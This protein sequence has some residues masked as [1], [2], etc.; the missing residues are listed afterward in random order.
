MHMRGRIPRLDERLERGLGV[1]MVGSGLEI[2]IGVGVGLGEGGVLS[3][4]VGRL[5]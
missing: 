2:G 4:G 5:G 1:G 3:G